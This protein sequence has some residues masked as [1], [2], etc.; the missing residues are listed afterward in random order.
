M[1]A[2]LA[3]PPFRGFAGFQA[4]VARRILCAELASWRTR[5]GEHDR[6]RCSLA[7]IRSAFHSVA[8]SVL[9]QQWLDQEQFMVRARAHSLS[10]QT[11]ESRAAV[12]RF[13]FPWAIVLLLGLLSC[14]PVIAPKGPENDTPAILPDAFLTRDGLRLPLRH[15]DAKNPRV[16]VVALHGMSDYSN[17]FDMPATWWAT[18]GITT[19]AYDQRAFGR[20]PHAGL[21]AG[22]DAF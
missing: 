12:R 7:R 21:W 15:W 20:A 8:S 1:R 5:Q 3:R 6:N 16:I 11:R 4:D 22:G 17:A 18:V 19:Y 9:A 2:A 13:G 10:A 14:A